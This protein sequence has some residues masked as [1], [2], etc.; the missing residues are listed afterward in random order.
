M[1]NINY[2]SEVLKMTY[3]INQYKGEPDLEAL[4]EYI[5]DMLSLAVFHKHNPLIDFL[6]KNIISEVGESTIEVLEHPLV[7]K[8][9]ENARGMIYTIINNNLVKNKLNKIKKRI[10][11][12]ENT[13]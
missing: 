4:H 11:H 3:M 6:S 2:D 5:D 12:L 10:K 7:F 9:N 1:K 8:N 13:W